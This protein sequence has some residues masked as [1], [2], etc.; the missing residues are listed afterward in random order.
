A[1]A[2]ATAG[3][4]ITFTVTALDSA[5]QA[6]PGY[7]G[8]VAFRSTDPD[9]ALP[10]NATLTNGSGTFSATLSTAGRRNRTA[11]A[12]PPRSITGNSN[13]IVV[14][15]AAASLYRLSA[16]VST[17]A[18]VAFSFT[19]TA[20]DPFNNTATG[21][22]GSIRFSSTDGQATLPANSSLSNGVGTFS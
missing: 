18:G 6:V 11:T 12:T 17:T 20:L 4:A 16:P 19:V 2:A 3:A 14:G 13:A 10:A 8:T 15:A 1:P 22:T 9:A 21:Y 5:G 7:S